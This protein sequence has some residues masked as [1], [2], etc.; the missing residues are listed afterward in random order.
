MNGYNTPN[1]TEPG[2]EVAHIGGT[3]VF[4]DGSKIIGLPVGLVPKAK[5]VH[6][7][8]ATNTAGIRDDLNAVIAALKSVGLMETE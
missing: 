8:T 4:E 7:S 1:Y 2:G 5:A 3:V 6:E